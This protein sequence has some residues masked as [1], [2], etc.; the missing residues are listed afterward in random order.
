[1]DNDFIFS[2]IYWIIVNMHL[3]MSNYSQPSK[4]I[5]SVWRSLIFPSLGWET[6]LSLSF[7][8]VLFCVTCFFTLHKLKNSAITCLFVP[9]RPY[10]Q[11]YLTVVN[12]KFLSFSHGT[13]STSEGCHSS[14]VLE[15]GICSAIQPVIPSSS[16]SSLHL[17]C[18]CCW[19]PPLK[20]HPAGHSRLLS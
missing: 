2:K 10:W 19:C 18:F 5:H 3:K 13:S 17:S 12:L 11:E 14:Y 8:L 15:C 16:S 7:F 1:M 6:Y 9:V 20:W 4:E